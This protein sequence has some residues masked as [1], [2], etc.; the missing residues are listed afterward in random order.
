[1]KRTALTGIKRPVVISK[2]LGPIFISRNAATYMNVCI[3]KS[4]HSLL[5]ATAQ[6]VFLAVVAKYLIYVSLR[7]GSR[8]LIDIIDCQVAVF[9]QSQNSKDKDM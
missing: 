9:L 2:T 8:G 4:T 5:K 7:K 1:M 3:A 6:L